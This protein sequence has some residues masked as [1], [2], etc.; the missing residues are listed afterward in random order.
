MKSQFLKLAAAFAL[1][2]A[3]CAADITV[4]TNIS[5]NTNWTKDNSYT[6][7]G[8]VFV[9]NNTTLT[10]EA[11]TVIKGR[12]RAAQDAS[13]LVIA[14]GAKIM[15]EGTPAAPIIFTAQADN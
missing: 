6:L 1:P 2:G 11:G 13:A 9:T 5:T 4:N 3:L 12:V 8:R 15:A 10:I 7:E 14:R